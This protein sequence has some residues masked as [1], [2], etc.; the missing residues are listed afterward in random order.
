MDKSKLRLP[1]LIQIF[2]TYNRTDGKSP[3]T[4][5]W[6]RQNL[7]AFLN[8]LT[9]TGRP[10][11][12]GSIDENVVREY[13]LWYQGRRVNDHAIKAQSVNCRVRSLWAF[14]NW[15]YRR[16]YTETHLL[17]D[18]RPP[19]LPVVM[20]DTLSEDEV[21]GIMAT[22]DR[23]TASGS[24][25]TAIMAILLDTGLR[26][27]ELAGLEDEDVHIEEQYLKVMGKGAKE[28]MVA[29][30]NTSRNALLK[31]ATHFRGEPAHPGIKEFFLILD[32]YP[33]SKEAVKSLLR[34]IATEAGVPRLHAH[35]CR[36]TYATNFL[37]NGGNVLLL[38][39][40][41]GHTTLSMVDRYVHLATSRVAILSRDYSPLDRLG[42][43]GLRQG[44]NR[45]RDR[46]KSGVKIF[47]RHSR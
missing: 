42:I 44:E 34:R 26:L 46:L 18:V 10:V 33:M 37:V 13:I 12:L 47:K 41:L 3:D 24:R 31:Y 19:R 15:L 43:R 39:Q 1:E 16:G 11:T 4:L 23:S 14:F 27:S 36:H 7:G 5:R 30:G 21:A 29:F 35:L 25:S 28:R 20:V 8:W 22:I 38:K 2:D 45:Y 6:Y 9:E 32:G 40:N 17:Q